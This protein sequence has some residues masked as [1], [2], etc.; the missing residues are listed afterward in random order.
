[1]EFLDIKN[2]KLTDDEF[3]SIR[4]EVLKTWE[5]GEG[6]RDIKKGIDYQKSLPETKNFSLKLK[7]AKE[8][9]VTLVQPRAGVGLVENH[10]ELLK[11]LENEGEADLLPSTIDSYTRQNQYENCAEGIRREKESMVDG[12][13]HPYLNGFPAVNHGV[14][15]CRRVIEATK[16]PVQVRHG[17]PDARLLAEIT[18]AGG[19]TSYEGGG[20]SYNIPYAKNIP[21]E[22]TIKDWQYVDR[23]TGIYEEAGVHIN[24]EPY[25]PLTGTLVP[26]CI[27]HSVAI[28]EALRTD[29]ITL[30]KPASAVAPVRIRLRH[31]AIYRRAAQPNPQSPGKRRHAVTGIRARMIFPVPDSRLKR[32]HQ[33]AAAEQACKC[34]RNHRHAGGNPVREIIRARCKLAEFFIFF[35]TVSPAGVQ[36]VHDPQENRSGGKPRK[37]SRQ[38]AE[39]SP[40]KRAVHRINHIFAE[41]FHGSAD[42][43]AFVQ[44]FRI[45]AHDHAERLSCR[46]QISV[47]QRAP[48]RFRMVNQ[49]PQGDAD[50]QPGTGKDSPAPYIQPPAAPC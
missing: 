22:R 15:G 24:R 3:N 47:F 17:T 23:L 30:N 35:I 28:I 41:R 43:I 34:N 38:I 19:F 29:K 14:E 50:I 13:F 48:D 49:A 45:T 6:V 18:Y 40:E 42:D 10:I 39:H 1:M 5:T 32:P 31:A 37:T 4:E 46:R 2:K 44:R 20:I 25:G 27:S 33:T 12:M 11:Y 36:R 9:K 16:S 8:E 7:K 21:I 26:P